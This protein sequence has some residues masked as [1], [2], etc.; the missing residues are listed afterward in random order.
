VSILPDL[1]LRAHRSAAV[2]TTP[3]TG[4]ERHLR[5]AVFGTPPDP[6]ATARLLEVLR[7][8][9][10]GRQVL[11]PGRLSLVTRRRSTTWRVPSG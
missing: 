10:G 11:R 6:P 8:D 4:G 5:A 3:L 9:A 7:A 1:A 2:R